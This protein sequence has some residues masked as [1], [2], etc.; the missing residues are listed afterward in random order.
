M[1]AGAQGGSMAGCWSVVARASAADVA[2]WPAGAAGCEAGGDDG[3]EASG[4]GTGDGVAG[5]DNTT[6]LIATGCASVK[7]SLRG[8][9][10][11]GP[12]SATVRGAVW[13]TVS[14]WGTTSRV[15]VGDGGTATTVA[16]ADGGGIAAWSV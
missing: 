13:N 12:P 11:A 4:S 8:M 15:A 6:W 14:V 3:L 1:S 16:V 7:R 10:G 9:A 5:T 2:A